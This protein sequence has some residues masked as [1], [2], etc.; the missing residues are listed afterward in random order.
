MITLQT[1][2]VQLLTGSSLHAK[3]TAIVSLLLDVFIRGRQDST[4]I[5]QSPSFAPWTWAFSGDEE[6]YEAIQQNLKD[7]GVQDALCPVRWCTQEEKDILDEQWSKVFAETAVH[8]TGIPRYPSTST[9]AVQLGDASHC[10]RCRS[11]MSTWLKRC[12]ACH[13]AYYCSQV[14]QT[15]DWQQHKESD[16]PANRSNNY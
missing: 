6:I 2:P 12:S 5:Q 4:G 3:I 1:R 11:S 16:C 13:E 7:C 15:A 9:R 10:H 14:C 8:T